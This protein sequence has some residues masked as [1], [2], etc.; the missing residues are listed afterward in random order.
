MDFLGGIPGAFRFTYQDYL[1]LPEGAAYEIL[2]GDLRMT[3]APGISHQCV[4]GNLYKLLE[5]YSEEHPGAVLMAP[6]D[7]VLAEDTV[8][9]PDLIF[10]SRERRGIVQE[11]GV[12]GAPDLVVEVLSPTSLRVDRMVKFRLYGRHGVPE[13]WLVDHAIGLVEIYGLEETGYEKIGQ[14][15]G[16]DEVHS[17]VLSGLHFTADKV[18]AGPNW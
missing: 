11:R 18:F 7:M 15:S 5:K 6:V 12:F 17:H 8:L 13:L 3:P 4:I 16:T 1:S 2:E 9:Q 14:Y 10:I